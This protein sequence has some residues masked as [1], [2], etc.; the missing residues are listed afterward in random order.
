MSEDPL[1]DIRATLTELGVPDAYGRDPE[2]PVYSE[3]MHTIEVGPNIVGKTQ[4]LEASTAAVWQQ[5]TAKAMSEGINVLMVSGFRTFA[6]QADLIR[7][8]L[9]AGQLIGDI[10]KVNVAPGYSQHHT[11]CAIDI[12]TPGSKP[13]QE[14]F[15]QSAAFAWLTDNAPQFGFTL[16]YPRNNPLG[17]IYEPWHWYRHA[18]L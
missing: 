12:A 8:K 2:L 7:N 13:L 15:E 6:Y 1:D 11:G 3:C 18:D 17:L 16:S 5:M 9:K 14:E 10:L 4:R